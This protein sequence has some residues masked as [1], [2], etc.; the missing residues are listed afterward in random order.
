MTVLR[1]SEPLRAAC[2]SLKRYVAR[3]LNGFNGELPGAN[4]L[5]RVALRPQRLQRLQSEKRNFDFF[6]NSF[7]LFFKVFSL[8]LF[9]FLLFF[10]SFE[11][12]LSSEVMSAD[13]WKALTFWS[14]LTGAEE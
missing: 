10:F 3:F 13:W 14:L 5:H 11:S 2:G 9:N 1:C 6:L 8:S 7:Q 4:R 12:L